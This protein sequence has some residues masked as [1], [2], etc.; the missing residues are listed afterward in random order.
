MDGPLDQRRNPL[1]SESRKYRKFTTQQ[2]LVIVLGGLRGKRTVREVCR[3]HEISETEYCGWRDQ[4]LQAGQER[5]AGREEPQGEHESRKKVAEL[6]DTI[7]AARGIRCT[8]RRL[9]M[10]D[11]P[12]N[13]GDVMDVVV[14]MLGIAVA[15]GIA[16]KRHPTPT[17]KLFDLALRSAHARLGTYTLAMLMQ[18][19]LDEMHA[20]AM[21]SITKSYVP[22][23][24]TFGLHPRDV[25]RW[26]KCF[27]QLADEL[28]DLMLRSVAASPDLHLSD[29]GLVVRLTS[30]EQ[31]EP[32]RPSFEARMSSRSADRARMP[33]RGSESC[34]LKKSTRERVHDGTTEE[35][36]ADA[37]TVVETDIT[38]TAPAQWQLVFGEDEVE[39]LFGE[40]IVG[41]GREADIRIDAQD[42]SRAHAR[43]ALLHDQITLMDLESGNGTFVN[44]K[45]IEIAM[46]NA[47]DHVRFGST[48]AA[49][50]DRV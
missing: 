36:Q 7:S 46:L 37:M 29:A 45:Q 17:R 42:V 19:M 26:G 22:N 9:I 16:A 27:D 18:R 33:A 10:V 41:R 24:M 35:D 34:G 47:G 15:G 6:E 1:I 23:E 39:L 14:L 28:V 31:A 50:L 11:R 49:R 8:A 20:S 12:S 3:E 38:A 30:D 44:G 40:T 43:L 5:L 32:G 13:R 2:E 4:L 21:P 48:A 25:R